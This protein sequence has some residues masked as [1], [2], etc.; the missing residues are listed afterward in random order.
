MALQD[1]T[2]EQ[3]AEDLRLQDETMVYCEPTRRPQ[4]PPLHAGT[5]SVRL[6][7]QTSP[8]ITSTTTAPSPTSSGLI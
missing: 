8:S 5:A 3:L 6:G 2:V 7:M 4:E 1:F